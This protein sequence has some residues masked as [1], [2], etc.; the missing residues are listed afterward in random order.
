MPDNDW[1]LLPSPQSKAVIQIAE[2][3]ASITNG[4][5]RAEINSTGDLTFFNA[6]NEI[7]LR[8]FTSRESWGIK[9]RGRDFQ[10]VPGGD[11]RL[12]ARFESDPEERIFGMGQY[13][14]P[15]LSVKGCSLEL[16]H[17]NSQA[18][19]PFAV[20][21]LGY[22]FLWNNPAIGN[23]VF[24]RNITEWSAQSTKIMDY[25]I[26]A[27][28]EPAEILANY[29]EVTGTVPIMPGYG[30]GLWQSK[31]RYQTQDELLAIA[32]E[33]K[34]R[35]LPIDVIVADFF[36][37][38]MQGEYKFDPDYWPDQLV[39]PILF[40]G[41]RNREVYLPAGARWVSHANREV[42]DG[43]Q[44]VNQSAPLD[45]MPVFFRE[46]G[47]AWSLVDKSNPA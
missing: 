12:T 17:R 27:G 42:F 6:K 16:A 10:A 34:R 43:G 24:G 35:G 18:S 23:V 22:G 36:H 8:E 1:A 26:T 2:K 33:Y 31:L 3:E 30:L 40:E 25:W 20:S 44:V 28:D 47:S 38:P 9:K 37:W 21:S 39:A 41:Q 32:R 14:Q 7:L 15:Q 45:Q 29:A 13:Q 5:I 19:I 46:D 4:G 11:Y